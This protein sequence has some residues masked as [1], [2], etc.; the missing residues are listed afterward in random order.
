MSGRVFI[1][2]TGQ[3]R[4]EVIDHDT[5][6]HLRTLDGFPEAAGVVAAD[7]EVLVTNRG[8][9]SMAWI[10]AHTL[11]TRAIVDTG[12]RPNGVAIYRI[13]ASR[14][15]LA[16]AMICT[17]LNCKFSIWTA[18]ENGRLSCLADLGGA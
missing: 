2:H 14:S 13:C 9:A 4:V 7:G 6:R 5:K 16:S 10:D 15:L 3:D 11:K 8:A 1:A 12:V 18:L 17:D